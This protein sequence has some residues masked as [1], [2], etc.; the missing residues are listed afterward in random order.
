MRL[1]LLR[2]ARISGFVIGAEVNEADEVVGFIVCDRNMER[3]GGKC[4]ATAAEAIL[5]AHDNFRGVKA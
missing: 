4:F 5:W 2:Y 1:K 3:F